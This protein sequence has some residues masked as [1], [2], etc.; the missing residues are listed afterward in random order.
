M[1]S[2]LRSSASS[3]TPGASGA[4]PFEQ[5]QR[6]VEGNARQRQRLLPALVALGAELHPLIWSHLE[7]QERLAGDWATGSL[8]RLLAAD[9]EQLLQLQRRYADGWLLAPPSDHTLFTELQQALLVEEL[10]Q[11]DRVTSELLRRLAGPDAQK[12]GYVY[13]SEVPAMPRAE[14]EFI[15]GCWWFYSSARYGF[16]VQRALL[17]RLSWRWEELWPKIGWKQDGVWTRYPGGFTWTHQAPEGH[18]PLLNQ[19]RGVRVM[20]A[21]MRHPAIDQAGSAP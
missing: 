15:D 18:M 2:G 20:D 6:F 5:L 16:R 17:D 11:A 1:L 8:L 7:Q 4:A 13:F 9:Q 21:L 10:E 12:R 3:V 19:L 14:L